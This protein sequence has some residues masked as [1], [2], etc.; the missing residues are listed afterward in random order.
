MIRFAS[1]LALV[2]VPLGLSPGLL[3]LF[4]FNLVVRPRHDSQR[5][6]ER[7]ELLIIGSGPRKK[8]VRLERL[9]IKIDDRR[10]VWIFSQAGARTSSDLYGAFFRAVSATPFGP[11]AYRTLNDTR[12]LDVI[13][14][15]S[16]AAPGC[17]PLASDLGI[18]TKATSL[19]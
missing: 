13:W 8:P 18:P 3:A 2:S 17:A 5:L 9:E 12:R 1:L 15:R 10:G 16:F 4:E 19:G 14:K 6:D 11:V 7:R